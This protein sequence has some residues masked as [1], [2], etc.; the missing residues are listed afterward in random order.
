[1]ELSEMLVPPIISRTPPI[2][3]SSTI[4]LWKKESKPPIAHQIL[5]I[6]LE[7]KLS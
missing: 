4:D 6:D 5:R 2:L 3:M 7:L 1:M